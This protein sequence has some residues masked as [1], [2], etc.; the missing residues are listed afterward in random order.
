M[1]KPRAG[2]NDRT[3]KN[4]LKASGS[5]RTK[6]AYW[7]AG[8]VAF[9]G[10][11]VVYASQLLG[12]VYADVELATSPEIAASIQDRLFFVALVFFGSFVAFLASAVLYLLIIGERVGGPVVAICAY[13]EELRK[14][15]FDHRRTLRDGDE[16]GPIMDSLQALAETLKKTRSGT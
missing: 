5:M 10:V 11:M 16:L 3:I 1:D 6:S 9:V 13:I 7:L 15:N 14:G 12:Q 4:F 2:R 8:G